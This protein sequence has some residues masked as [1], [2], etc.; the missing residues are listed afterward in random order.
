MDPKFILNQQ[1]I[2][3]N[4]KKNGEGAGRGRKSMFM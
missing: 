3:E 2:L 4:K 1:N